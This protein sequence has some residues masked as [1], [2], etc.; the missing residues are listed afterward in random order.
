MCV[1]AQRT[2]TKQP[3][4]QNTR[5]TTRTTTKVTTNTTTQQHFFI[6]FLS[7]CCFSLFI[8]FCCLLAYFFISLSLVND[9]NLQNQHK[10][11]INRLSPIFLSPCTAPTEGGCSRKFSPIPDFAGKRSTKRGCARK[12]LKNQ[13][14]QI[15]KNSI[16]KN[17]RTTRPNGNDD[18][19]KITREI[20]KNPIFI[21]FFLPR[22][23]G[24]QRPKTI[25]APHTAPT[26]KE[27][28]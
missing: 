8:F 17:L 27:I 26:P 5:R 2:T 1:I 20:L 25:A 19:S 15:S 14:S 12:F 9:S 11:K 18:N 16:Y 13:K 4:Q 24:E 6:F 22:T 21:G 10:E 7:L 23:N 28:L 3:Q